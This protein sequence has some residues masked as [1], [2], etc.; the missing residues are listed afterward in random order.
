[1]ESLEGQEAPALLWDMVGT[2][3]KALGSLTHQEPVTYKRSLDTQERKCV[4]K[5]GLSLLGSVHCSGWP[6]VALG[7]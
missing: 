7:P 2:V 5:S 1:M 6:G 3:S 4:P